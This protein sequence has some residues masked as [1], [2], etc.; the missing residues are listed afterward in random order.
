MWTGRRQPT[1]GQGRH[2]RAAQEG[3]GVAWQRPQ[4]QRRPV[5]RICGGQ[6]EREREGR[7]VAWQRQQR[8]REREGR[9]GG[10]TACAAADADRLEEVLRGDKTTESNTSIHAHAG[11]HKHLGEGDAPTRTHAR[12]HTWGKAMSS[13]K[14]QNRVAPLQS[15]PVIHLP[16]YNI[17]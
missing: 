14:V 11:A 9:G 17:V 10:F 1:R 6:R 12:T 13:M 4:K 5:V 16:T 3:G 8:E 15:V 7:G 2:R